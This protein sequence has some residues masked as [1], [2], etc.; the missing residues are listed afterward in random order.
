M[1]KGNTVKVLRNAKNLLVH[2]L[3]EKGNKEWKNT[4]LEHYS[5]MIEKELHKEK[6]EMEIDMEAN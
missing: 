6:M 5:V 4:K 1:G 3:I 2:T